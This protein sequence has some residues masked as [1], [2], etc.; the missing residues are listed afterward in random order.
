VRILMLTLAVVGAALPAPR[1][2]SVAPPTPLPGLLDQAEIARDVRGIAHLTT[3]ND[4]DL[5]FLQGWVHASDRLF[6]M[7]VGRRVPSGTFA[8]LAGT[9]ALP[10][11][12]QYRTFGLRRAAE[13]SLPLLRASTR[14]A[15]DAYADGINA[16]VAS[17]PLPP[18]YAALG[19]DAF[20]PWTPLDSVTIGKWLS[21]LLSFGLD[22]QTTLDYLAYTATGAALGFDGA[23]LFAED[24]F[25]VAPFTDA[26]TVPD[27]GASATMARQP[28]PMPATP[29]LSSTTVR[30]ARRWVSGIERIP[31][32]EPILDPSARAGSNEWAVAGSLT[33]SGL[34]ILANDPHLPLVAPS[35]L[36]PLH[37]RD[38]AIDVYGESFAGSPGVVLGHNRFITWGAT[39]NPMDVTDVFAE[40]V[41]PDPGSPS[42]LSTVYQGTLEHVVAIPEQFRANVGGTVV[43][44]PSSPDVPATTLIVPRRNHGPIVALDPGTGDALSIQYAGWSGTRELDAFLAMDRARTLDQ[45]RAALMMFDVGSENFSYVDRTGSIAMFSAGEMPLREDLEA[46][47]VHGVPPWF[48]R[49]GSGGNEWLP[50]ASPA[51]QAL[52]YR[53]LPPEEMPHI[54]DPPAGFFLNA[55]NDPVGTTLDNDPLNQLRRTGGIYYLNAMN[56]E[57]DGY[58]AG[59][60]TE[61]LRERLGDGSPITVDEMQAMQADVTLIDA[62]VFVPYIAQ[63]WDRADGSPTPEL[64]AFRTD[65]D[66]TEAVARLETWDDSTPTGIAEGYDAADGGGALEPPLDEEVAD[67]VAATIFAAWRSR[68]L[69]NTIDATLLGLGLNPPETLQPVV[70]LRR[71]LDRYPQNKGVGV[72]GVD[73]FVVPGVSDPDDERDVLMLQ[74]LKEA[75]DALASPSFAAAFGGSTDQDDY[76][77]GRLHRI[78]FEHVL[79]RAFS[80]PPAAGAFPPPLAGFAGIPTDG[81]FET[82]DASIHDPRALSADGFTF[83]FGPARRSVSEV[84][85][86]LGRARWLSSLPGGVSGDVASPRYVDLLPAWL[87]NEAYPQFMRRS[88]LLPTFVWI[89]RLTPV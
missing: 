27:A 60:I 1:V 43:P 49:D 89:Q 80:V 23:A 28:T 10:S 69:A 7:D 14:D 73:F 26:S 30:L 39:Q 53:I 29:R 83:S 79:G 20:E 66:V 58:R 87:S 44:V 78:V 9:V 37:L 47:T 24:V 77:W 59:R 68:I 50:L 84:S 82:V 45:F 5:F 67:S 36:Y 21:F 4:H 12:V 52:P 34:P 18:E 38:D 2:A 81:G 61:M 75:L 40:H 3:Q 72:S 31:T 86:S 6:Q 88:D 48:I 35:I 25:T 74:S 46:G 54:V 55:N 70:A 62:E 22:I 19:L 15:L 85:S 17:H 64:A 8:E 33:A 63:A 56:P 42:G 65:R 51:G 41:V 32:L 16:W 71:L 13:R 57:Y 11:D 76:R